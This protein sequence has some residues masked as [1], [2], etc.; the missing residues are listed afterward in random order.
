MCIYQY[1]P[2]V[3]ST[4]ITMMVWGRIYKYTLDSLGVYLQI[5][6]WQ[7]EGLFTNVHITFEI[8]I[9]IYTWHVKS[10]STDIHLMVWGCIY[11]YTHDSLGVFKNIHLTVWRC[12]YKTT[13]DSLRVYLQIYPWKFWRLSTNMT[14]DNLGLYPQ[15]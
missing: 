8:Y 5:Y 11:K 3:L 15:I 9:L 2:G 4:N 1:T 10:V 13:H 14:P 7:F 6:T 12:I